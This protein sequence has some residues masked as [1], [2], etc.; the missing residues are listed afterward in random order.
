MNSTCHWSVGPPWIQHSVRPAPATYRR[1]CSVTPSCSTVIGSGSGRSTESQPTTGPTASTRR[2]PAFGVVV[3]A[4]SA[5]ACA[6]RCGRRNDRSPTHDSW[7]CTPRPISVDVARADVDDAEPTE[8]ALVARERDPFT[9]GRRPRY[10]RWPI[11][12][13]GLGVLERFVDERT[14]AAT[15]RLS[16][17]VSSRTPMPEPSGIVARLLHR[18]DGLARDSSLTLAVERHVLRRGPCPTACPARSTPATRRS[19]RRS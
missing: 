14:V 17:P 5:S 1:A 4:R 12:H 11:H 9:V 10:E 3:D 16:Q 6:L 18:A 15:Q 7:P 19:S 8:A 13:D 2:C